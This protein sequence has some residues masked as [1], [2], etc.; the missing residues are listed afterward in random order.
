M[1]YFYRENCCIKNISSHNHIEILTTE[2]EI[3]RTMEDTFEIQMENYFQF[4]SL[5]K[6]MLSVKH[7]DSIKTLSGE[8]VFKYLVFVF[9]F[10]CTTSQNLLEKTKPSEKKKWNFQT[11]HGE[12]LHYNSSPSALGENHIWLQKML[13]GLQAIGNS[14]SLPPSFPLF[15]SQIDEIPNAWYISLFSEEV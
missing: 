11:E 6:A 14:F 8:Q 2:S 13:R 10:T 9:F 1:K 5:W 4:R 7:E 3:Q 12:K 15:L